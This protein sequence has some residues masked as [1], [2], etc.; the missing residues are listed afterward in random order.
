MVHAV[1]DAP[2]LT[3]D[4]ENLLTKL[5]PKCKEKKTSNVHPNPINCD[6]L[7]RQM[8][9]QKKLLGPGPLRTPKGFCAILVDA[10]LPIEDEPPCMRFM[11][12]IS[13]EFEGD[14]NGVVTPWPAIIG[15]G[16]RFDT[17]FHEAC[18]LEQHALPGGE[19]CAQRLKAVKK[20]KYENKKYKKTS[21][22]S[23]GF[24]PSDGNAIESLTHAAERTSHVPDHQSK[25]IAK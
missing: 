18:A 1:T 19:S 12:D 13:H 23:C 2:D 16:G 22:P 8:L 7:D 3:T 24:V 17:A 6:M 9:L 11:E 5:V 14:A 4:F 20:V 25:S 21:E 10:A 15:Q